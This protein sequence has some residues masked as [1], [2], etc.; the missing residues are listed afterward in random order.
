MVNERKVAFP[1]FDAVDWKLI[2]IFMEHKTQLY[3]MWFSRHSL[4]WCRYDKIMKGWKYW[5]NGNCPYCLTAP[6]LKVMHTFS[7][8]LHERENIKRSYMEIYVTYS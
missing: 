8:K 6:E 5:D 4:G 2:E 3:K 7:R 1:L